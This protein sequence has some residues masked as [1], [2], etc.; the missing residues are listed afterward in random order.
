VAAIRYLVDDVDA[1]VQFYVDRLGFEVRE[2][3]GPVV[4]VTRGDLEL[5]LSGP[6]SSAG[7]RPE[8]PNRFVVGVPDLDRALSELGI[9]PEIVD[10]AAG[11]WAVVEDPSG[12]AVE[13]FESS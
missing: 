13:L 1:A 10:G 2:D 4:I 12:N 3:W 6:E 5:W 9:E 11:R 8:R 7:Q